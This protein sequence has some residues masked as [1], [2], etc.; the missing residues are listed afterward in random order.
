M[1]VQLIG[2]DLNQVLIGHDSL[3]QHAMA[4]LIEHGP[5]AG[6]G[7][8]LL[9]EAAA[10]N[11][12]KPAAINEATAAVLRAGSLVGRDLAGL[13]PVCWRPVKTLLNRTLHN[14]SP[15]DP[16]K[17]PMGVRPKFYSR[18]SALKVAGTSQASAAIFPHK[19]TD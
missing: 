4:V 18:S 14:R 1:A 10:I 2:W 13:Q 3:D 12:Q 19:C 9:Q 5:A 15:A 8:W 17:N 6:I 11:T 7:A 16:W